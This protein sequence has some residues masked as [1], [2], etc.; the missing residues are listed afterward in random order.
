MRS[1]LRSSML[2]THSALGHSSLLMG[3]WKFREATEGEE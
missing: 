1:A 3:P 2:G